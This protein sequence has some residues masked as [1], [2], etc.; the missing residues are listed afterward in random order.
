MLHEGSQS[1]VPIQE[2]SFIGLGMIPQLPAIY[3][4]IRDVSAAI[5]AAEPDLL[6]IIDSPE[7]THRIAQR[8]RRQMP[9]IPIID[10][11]SPSVW[12]WRP[13]RARSMRSYVDHI[14]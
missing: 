3:R 11:E 1:L 13:G 6:V 9:S 8:V 7:L 4:Y 10:Y 14:L 5:V 12:A 2:I